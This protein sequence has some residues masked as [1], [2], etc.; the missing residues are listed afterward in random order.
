[1]AISQNEKQ[2]NN[3]RSKAA[4]RKHDAGWGSDKIEIRKLK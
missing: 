1:M 2:M 4:I 3:G